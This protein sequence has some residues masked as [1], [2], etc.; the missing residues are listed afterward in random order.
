MSD[1]KTIR[2]E[3]VLPLCKMRK[4]VTDIEIGGFEPQT[5]DFEKKAQ[6]T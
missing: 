4:G 3:S 2:F 6:N 1:I 5:G